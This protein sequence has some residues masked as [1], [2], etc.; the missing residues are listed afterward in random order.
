MLR[1]TID[2]ISS[3][4]FKKYVPNYDEVCREGDRVKSDVAFLNEVCKRMQTSKT[5]LFKVVPHS[6]GG[7]TIIDWYNYV[8]DNEFVAMHVLFQN[9]RNT[10]QN[11]DVDKIAE[12]AGDLKEIADHVGFDVV[13]ALCEFIGCSWLEGK[14]HDKLREMIPARPA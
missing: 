13:D 9:I 7:Q 3:P 5:F 11:G 12:I 14:V 1:E 8:W 4:L 6:F 2:F 10:I